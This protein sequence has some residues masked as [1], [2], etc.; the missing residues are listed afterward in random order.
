MVEFVSL[1]L[2]WVLL[3]SFSRS[4]HI[5]LNLKDVYSVEGLKEEPY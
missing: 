1:M 2:T 5:D 4:D 3:G